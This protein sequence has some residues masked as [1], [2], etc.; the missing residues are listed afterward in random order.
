[1]GECLFARR[2][3]IHMV[4]IVLNPVFADNTWAEIVQA[5]RRGKV[6]DT[7][8]VGAQKRMA[9]DGTDYLIDIIGKDHDDYADGSGKA[10]LTFQL[11]DCYNTITTMNSLSTN[12][13]GWTSSRMRTVFLPEVKALLPTEVRA[14]LKEVSK[15]TSMGDAK[16]S[17]VTTADTLF[18]LSEAEVRSTIS[19]SFGGE[20]SRYEYYNRKSSVK[21]W[22]GTA[23]SWWT[24]SPRNVYD[25]Q[26]CHMTTGS[27]ISAIASA[28]A[29]LGVSFAFCF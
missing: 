12:V 22:S 26:F 9:I 15:R 4:P 19:E 14:G 23:N 17:I 27:D 25:T 11:H 10:P 20:G 2:G 3:A 21:Y 13:G 16:S 6:P 18:L 28:G 1:M 29:S 8:T 7:W 5:C 24:R